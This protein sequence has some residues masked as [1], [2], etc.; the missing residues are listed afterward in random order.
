M[1]F[2]MQ[3]EE[4]TFESLLRLVGQEDR[5]FVIWRE[6]DL[7]RMRSHPVKID[8]PG[9]FI[10]LSGGLELEINLQRCVIDTQH[11]LC[12]MSPCAGRIVSRSDDFRCVGIMFSKSYWK[13]LVF[14]DYALS[15]IA[16]RNAFVEI[17]DTERWRLKSFY[18]LICSCVVTEPDMCRDET[19]RHLVAGLAYQIKSICDARSAA[20]P[21]LSRN[22][23]LMYDFLDL[24]YREYKRHRRVAFYAE[25][26]SLTPRYLTTVVKLVSGKSAARWIEDYIILE[27][28]ILLR[29]SDMTV[30][31][32]AYELNFNDQSLFSK[33]FG[34]VAGIS[35]ERYRK[36]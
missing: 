1:S 10:C 23:K 3:G 12:F 13:N 29:N 22:E 26:L 5:P 14:Q 9:F 16:V 35:P 7:F 31:E 17:T 4:F 11:L 24:V 18:D 15:A 30:K 21:S 6:Q 34:R 36:Q 28:Q 20:L 25:A 8:V 2:R 27:A 19:L 32:I 33:Y